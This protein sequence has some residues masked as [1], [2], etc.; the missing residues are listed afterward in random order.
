MCAMPSATFFL[1]FLRARTPA[2]GAC[3]WVAICSILLL[4]R[5]R[6]ASGLACLAR[7][8]AG[9]GVGARALAAHR[10]AAAV[11]HPAIAAEVHEPLDAHRD[12]APQVAFD[13]EL[14]DLLAQP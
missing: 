13:R 4:R 6:R 2:F 5:G 11:A 7:S 3:D 12:F 8:L 9:A 1:T 14:G 10:Q